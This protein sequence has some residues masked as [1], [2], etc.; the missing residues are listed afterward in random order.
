MADNQNAQPQAEKN[1]GSK[2]TKNDF[3]LHVLLIMKQD[4]LAKSKATFAAWLEGPAGLKVR[5]DK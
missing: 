2:P 1:G 3:D 5:L 4:A